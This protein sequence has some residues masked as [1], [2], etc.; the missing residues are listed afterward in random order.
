MYDSDE[1][2]EL[3]NSRLWQ[4]PIT[5]DDTRMIY[6]LYSLDDE[7]PPLDGF[8][9]DDSSS[10]SDSS[11]SDEIDEELY[12]SLDECL[13]NKYFKSNDMMSIAQLV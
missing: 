8:Q 6:E 9:L 5:N 2:V 13:D 4:K 11:Y 7:P 3:N 12:T 10:I 1:S